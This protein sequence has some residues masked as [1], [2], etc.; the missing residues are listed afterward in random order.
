MTETATVQIDDLTALDALVLTADVLE[1]TKYNLPAGASRTEQLL[2]IGP[3]LRELCYHLD[4]LDALPVAALDAFREAAGLNT[5]VLGL[6]P[7]SAEL[8]L[9]CA[10]QQA[11][12]TSH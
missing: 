3:L 4:R 12:D 5:G 1:Q 6:M 9:T 8:V 11:A 10:L 7:T 2:A